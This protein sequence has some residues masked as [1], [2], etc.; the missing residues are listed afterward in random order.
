MPTTSG[1]RPLDML[2]RMRTQRFKVFKHLLDWFSEFL[3]YH[4]KD[5]QV[6]KE[7]DDLMSATRYG[8]MMLRFAEV[9]GTAEIEAE[10]MGEG[11]WM[12]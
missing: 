2:A 6:V 11:G 12:G 7:F 9:L 10:P 3:L 8:I 5:G 1:I 4:R